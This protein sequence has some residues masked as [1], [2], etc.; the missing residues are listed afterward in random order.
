MNNATGFSAVPAG[1]CSGSSFGNAGYYANFWSSSQD[2]SFTA[3]NR[4]LYFYDAN[5]NRY[6]YAK[7]YG[8][9]VRCLRD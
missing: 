5:V 8:I 9:S 6:H 1:Y 2:D 3:W 4:S 7:N